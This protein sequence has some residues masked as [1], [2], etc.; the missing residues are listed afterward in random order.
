MIAAQFS[1]W[2]QKATEFG[3]SVTKKKERPRDGPFFGA[4]AATAAMR[5]SSCQ[6]QKLNSL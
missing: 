1:N 6:R 3:K 2:P 5:K 4:S